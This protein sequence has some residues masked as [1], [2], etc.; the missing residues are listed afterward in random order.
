MTAASEG[1]ERDLAALLREPTR[2]RSVP[3]HSIRRLAQL[4]ESHGI[5]GL[6]LTRASSAGVSPGSR[7]MPLRERAAAQMAAATMR[8]EESRRVLEAVRRADLPYVALKGIALAHS[9]YPQPWLRERSDTDLLTREALLARFERVFVDLGYSVVP[10]LRGRLTLPQRHYV[11]ED[12]RGVRYAWDLHWRLTASQALRSAI[13][14]EAV[15]SSAVIVPALG[16]LVIPSQV[17]ALLIACIHRLAHHLDEKRLVWLWDI[18]LLLHAMAPH[19]IVEFHR[20]ATRDS[21]TAAAVARSLTVA[22][23]Y[24]AAPVPELLRPLLESTAGPE[25]TA[26]FLWSGSRRKVTYLVGELRAARPDER[27]PLL[28]ERILPSRSSMRERYP[29]IPSLLLPLAYVWRLA[30]G[31]PKWLVKT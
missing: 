29:S 17:H 28:R 16:G 13:D 26:A 22:R 27:L 23:D 12:P 3:V 19:E 2:L 31:I 14:E 5:A 8:E 6:L 24:V 9:V 15:W 25:S 7:W 11:R 21:N 1:S 10:Q 30:L 20:R 4:A 18:R